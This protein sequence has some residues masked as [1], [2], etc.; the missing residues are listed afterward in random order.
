MVRRLRFS[1]GILSSSKPCLIT[2]LTE[3]K[4]FEPL[5]VTVK[6]NCEET[7]FGLQLLNR[8]VAP[9]NWMLLTCSFGSRSVLVN[10]LVAHY[11]L[12]GYKISIWWMMWNATQYCKLKAWSCA[13]FSRTPIL[14]HVRVKLQPI[15]CSSVSFCTKFKMLFTLPLFFVVTFFF[16]FFLFKEKSWN[17]YWHFVNRKITLPFQVIFQLIKLSHLKC[18]Y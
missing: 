14:F 5:N 16:S 1:D 6:I 17:I 12:D 18:T 2:L 15:I 13:L 8:L 9:L 3:G 10:I 11:K 4:C 7:T